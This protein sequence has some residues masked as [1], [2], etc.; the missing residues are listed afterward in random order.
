MAAITRYITAQ[1]IIN[2]AAVECGLEPSTDV[3]AETNPSFVQLRNLITT[4]GQDLAET[5][6]WEILRREHTIV[7]VVP[8]DTGVYDLPA[9]FNYMIN[10]TGWERSENVPLG[11]PLS[12][13]QWSYLLGRDL[14]SYT[15]YASFRIME[16]KFN[17][18]PQPP[19]NGLDIHFEYISRGWVDS[20][21]SPGTFCDTVTE[22]S[23][24]VLFKP[25]LIVQYLRFKFLE[26]KGFASGGALG[27][28]EKAL[29][30]ATGGNKGAPML[31]AGARAAGIHYLD[32]RNIPNT[33]YG[34][35]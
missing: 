4:C 34:G 19:P 22:N 29:L 24:T 26:A 14:V 8:P 28:F 27:A 11:G 21:S 3:F 1:D 16:N 13:Q 32:F 30:E 35:P 12:P 2:R 10:Q 7:T 25:I 31:N 15:I 23:D 9:D 17:I 18:F 20:G 6:P 5:F 33:N